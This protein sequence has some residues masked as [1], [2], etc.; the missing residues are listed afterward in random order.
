MPEQKAG[1][2][3]VRGGNGPSARSAREGRKD[4]DCRYASDVNVVAGCWGYEAAQPCGPCFVHIAFYQGTAVYE[5]SPHLPPLLDDRLRD[6][7]ALHLDPSAMRYIAST[8]LSYLREQSCGPQR[9]M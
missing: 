3:R 6:R 5:V 9:L 4:L 7:L 1:G 2:A 8:W